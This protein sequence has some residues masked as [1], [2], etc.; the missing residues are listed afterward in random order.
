MATKIF[1]SSKTGRT[2]EISIDDDGQEIEV[3]E[4]GRGVGTI[5]L[6]KV[7][8]PMDWSADH[9]FITYL[10]LEQCRA[11]GVGTQCLLFHREQFQAPLIAARDDFVEAPDRDG[12]HLTGDGVPFIARMRELGIVCP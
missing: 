6:Q 4:G 2:F 11:Q 3:T 10:G 5:S 12:W 8:G 7:G 9:Y 1:T